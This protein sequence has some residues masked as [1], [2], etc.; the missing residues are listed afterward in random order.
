VNYEPLRQFADSYG[1]VLMA[2]FWLAFTGWAF[3]PGARQRN[4]DAAHMIF[5]GSEN[6]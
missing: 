2:F 6:G 5:E 3:R 1:L 4:R